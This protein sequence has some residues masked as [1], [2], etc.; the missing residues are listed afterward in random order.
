MNQVINEAYNYKI[1]KIFLL[2]E[3][4][5]HYVSLMYELKFLIMLHNY[6]V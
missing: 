1:Y 2:C 4:T 5:C 3:L 6:Y